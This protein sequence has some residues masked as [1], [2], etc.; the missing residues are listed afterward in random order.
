MKGSRMFAVLLPLAL[1][2]G[3]MLSGCGRSPSN[4]DGGSAGTG[5]QGKD[6]TAYTGGPVE[7]LVQDRNTGITEQEFQEYF[8]KPVKAKYPDITLKLTTEKDLQKLVA[9]GTP[10][11]LVAVSNTALNE[12]FELDFPEDL[13]PVI[14]RFNINP[15]SFEPSIIEV[16]K[17]LDR[18][19]T[20][21][22]SSH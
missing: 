16:L 2:G 14:K 7:L 18:K 15:D 17:G 3:V 1:I 10:P 13:T 6:P 4:T 19:S 8:A 12:Y 5:G 20:R 11:D 22:N 9:G 21:L